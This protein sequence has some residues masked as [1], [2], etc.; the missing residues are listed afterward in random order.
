M[1]TTYIMGNPSS[2]GSQY[3]AS[4]LTF[5]QKVKKKATNT[6][7]LDMDENDYEN[8]CLE[9]TKRILSNRR[10]EQELYG[11]IYCNTTKNNDVSNNSKISFAGAEITQKN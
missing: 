9:V 8:L 7:L 1:S 10:D 11:K 6:I 3:G 4:K 2:N 5:G